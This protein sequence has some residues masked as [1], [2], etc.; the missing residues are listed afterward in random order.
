MRKFSLAFV[1]AVAFAVS[2]GSKTLPTKPDVTVSG[3][4]ECPFYV[5]FCDVNNN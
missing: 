4:P 3:W 5:G 1:L 2:A